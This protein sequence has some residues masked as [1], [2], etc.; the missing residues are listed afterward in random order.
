MN[1]FSALAAT[2]GIILL[3]FGFILDQNYF[4][5]YAEEI[6]ECKPVTTLFIVSML[7]FSNS[8]NR[9]DGLASQISIMQIMLLTHIFSFVH[10]HLH[11]S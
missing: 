7:H 9:K 1:F 6:S 8:F 3:V 11:K 4:C 10:K 2:I 5:G